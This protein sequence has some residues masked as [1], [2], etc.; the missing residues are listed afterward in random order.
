ML[1]AMLAC[2]EEF[3]ASETKLF[4]PGRNTLKK[5][6]LAAAFT[7][8]L[9]GCAPVQCQSTDLQCGGQEEHLAETVGG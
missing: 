7:V 4:C 1:R 8:D 3:Q 5:T 6:S 2:I 9:P